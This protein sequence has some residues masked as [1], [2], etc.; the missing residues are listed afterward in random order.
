MQRWVKSYRRIMLQRNDVTGHFS[1]HSPLHFAAVRIDSPL[2]DVAVRFDSPLHF[3]AERSDS[4]AG[5]CDSPLHRAAGRFDSPL[6]DAAGSQQK[7]LKWLPTASCSGEIWLPAV[8]C[9]G[10]IW[11]PAAW[12][13]G[14]IWFPAASCSGESKFN[15]NNPSNLKPNFK[16]NWICIR[17]KGEYFRWKQ[18]EVENLAL[19]SL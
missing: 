13:S 4:L 8:K 16:K 7:L 5:Q 1:V 15:L 18:P 14:E 10:E 12:C 9:S 11:L 3:A 2:H 6:H 19:L 17:V